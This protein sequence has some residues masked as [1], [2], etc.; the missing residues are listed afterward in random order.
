[1]STSGN[2]EYKEPRD[3]RG[4]MDA[5]IRGASTRIPPF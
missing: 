1:M 4:Y 2:R 5:K 3:E